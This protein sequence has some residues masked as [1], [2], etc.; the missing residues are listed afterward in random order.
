MDN[1]G[2]RIRQMHWAEQWVSCSKQLRTWVKIV[3]ANEL[4]SW[5]NNI[6]GGGNKIIDKAISL[7]NGSVYHLHVIIC[8]PDAQRFSFQLFTGVWNSFCDSVKCVAVNLCNDVF[9]MFGNVETTV[10]INEIRFCCN[11]KLCVALPCFITFVRLLF[12]VFCFFI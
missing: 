2:D 5:L 3:S 12:F 10:I 6:L 4:A 7:F 1:W 9:V 8:R 11:V